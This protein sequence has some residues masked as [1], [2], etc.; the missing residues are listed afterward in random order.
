MSP[1]EARELLLDAAEACFG[2]FGIEK[3][4]MDDVAAEA[5]L[6]R[7]MLYRHFDG[8]DDLLVGVVGRLTDRYTEAIAAQLDP[9]TSLGDFIVDALVDLVSTARS[10]PGLAQL[11]VTG[12]VD[13]ARTTV[14]QSADVH[15]QA[16]AFT[17]RIV[18]LASPDQLGE[19]REGLDLDALTDHLVFT[20]LALILGLGPAADD[21]PQLRSYLRAFLLPAVLADPPPL[22]PPRS[23]G[24]R[25]RARNQSTGTER[26]S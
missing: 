6:S 21:A 17:R 26:K 16:L 20:G 8:R 25:R 19:L 9:T 4:T 18:E 13:L 7:G 14:A 12:G 24:A 11:F 23:S 22:S 2:R 10:D 15:E 1:A 3:T 5:G